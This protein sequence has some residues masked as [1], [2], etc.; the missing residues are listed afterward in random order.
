M[1][2]ILFELNFVPPANCWAIFKHMLHV[3]TGLHV[4]VQFC[5]GMSS[6]KQFLEVNQ[7][8]FHVQQF[9]VKIFKRTLIDSMFYLGN[10]QA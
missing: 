5:F 2:V 9:Y 4:Y 10:K 1:Q 7:L 3:T 6:V 8:E